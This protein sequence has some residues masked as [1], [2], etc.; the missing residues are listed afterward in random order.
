M[1]D[2]REAADELRE[3]IAGDSFER[4]GDLLRECAASLETLPVGG[5]S[6]AVGGTAALLADLRRQALARRAHLAARLDELNR[7][8]P[9]LTRSPRRR[10]LQ[11]EG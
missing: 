3:A 7:L 11:M 6:A 9:Y 2:F 4:A 5:D 1:K 8:T 10:R